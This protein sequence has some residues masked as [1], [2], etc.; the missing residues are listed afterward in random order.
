MRGSREIVG[1]AVRALYLAS[2]VTDLYAE[3][4]DEALLEAML[5][6]WDDLTSAKTYL[7]GGVGSRHADESIG[8]PYEL[9]PD[10]AYCETCAAI[11][12]IMW[13]WRMLLVTGE[14]RFADQLERTLYNGFMSGLSLDGKT[15]F[16]VNPLRSRGGHGRNTVGPGCVLPAEHHAVCSHRCTTT[17]RR[18]RGTAC[19]STSTQPATIRAAGRTTSSYASTLP[20]RGTGRSKSR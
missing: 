1:H 20:I 13:N 11:A 19:R 9:P 8:D 3:T 18:R 10:R 6:Q 2:G 12:S 17:S 14:A 15:F 16:Y 4:G 5:A 7:T